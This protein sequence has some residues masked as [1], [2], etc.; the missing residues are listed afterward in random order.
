MMKSVAATPIYV[1]FYAVPKFTDPGPRFG[2][3]TFTSNLAACQGLAT[4]APGS[5]TQFHVAFHNI[6]ELSDPGARV[7]LSAFYCILHIVVQPRVIVS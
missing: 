4:L 3:Y 6:P 7:G 2:K 1:V 5:E